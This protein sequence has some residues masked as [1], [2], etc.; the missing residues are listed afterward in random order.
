MTDFKKI[1]NL[2]GWGT[3]FVSM[4]V[5]V[6]TVE[7]TASFWDCGEFIA[8]A[9]KLEVSHPPGAPLFML[10]GRLFSFLSLDDPTRVAYWINISSA[11]ASA[12]SVTFLYWS[13]VMLGRKLLRTTAWKETSMQKMLLV[14][15]GAIGALSFAFT[16]SFWFS[17]VEGEVYAMSSFFTA[18]VFWAML[19]WEMVKDES[20]A[21]KWLL[22]IA[23]M[24]GLSSG[25]HL[26]GLVTLPALG[27][28]YYFKKYK[29]PNLKGVVIALFG[30]LFLIGFINSFIITGLPTAAEFLEIQF[31]N[32]LGLPFGSGALFMAVL[33]VVVLVVSIRVTA[34]KGFVNLNTFLLAMSF[35]L[36]G[37]ACYGVILIRS[38]ANPPI[39]QNNPENAIT[40]TSYLKREQYGSRPLLKGPYFN[41]KVSEINKGSATYYKDEEGYKISDYKTEYSYNDQHLLPRMWSSQPSHVQRYQQI[42]GLRPGESPSFFDNMGFLFNHQLGHMYMRYFMFNFAGRESDIQNADFLAPWEGN[43]GVPKVIKENKGRNQYFA[44]PLILGLIGF[45]F[46][47][48]MDPKRFSATLMFFIL[49]GAALVIYL[50]SAPI[51]PRERDYIYVGSYYVF[52][53]WIGLAVIGLGGA[54]QRKG[55]TALL[56][57]ALSL[58]CPVLLLTENWDDHD[59]SDR[60]FSVDS[61]RNFLASCAP[62]AILFTGGDNDTFP[63]WYVQ[64]V[65]GFR[66]DVRVVVMSYYNTDWYIDQTRM[67]MNDSEP[68]PY[69]LGIDNYRQ[70]TNDYLMVDEELPQHRNEAIDLKQY[71]ELLKEN[72]RFLKVPLRSGDEINA[73]ISRRLKLN[74]DI[75]KVSNADIIPDRLKS[76]MV[77]SM[78]FTVNPSTRALDKAQMMMLDL[79][80]TNEWERPIYFNYT[81]VN[82]LDVDLS[83]YLVQ[84]GMAYRLLPLRN[85]GYTEYM[86]NLDVM[87]DNMMNKFQFRGMD[88]PDVNINED[89]RGFAQNHRSTFTALADALILEGDTARARKVLDYGMEVM[90]RE[91]VP[92]DITSTGFVN[93]Y[94]ALGETEFAIKLGLEMAEEFEDM[95][96]YHLDK[97]RMDNDFRK[98]AGSLQ[99]L[100]LHFENA[101]LLEQAN[102]ITEKLRALSLRIEVENELRR[103]R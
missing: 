46:Q 2:A 103:N 6:L 78:T 60:Y 39:D 28:I 23:Y 35:V 67:K 73:L 79:I 93:S 95:I 92:Y 59:R 40:F 75:E 48:N 51:E 68:F 44:I 56:V 41:D 69:S 29:T 32:S 90:P 45:F 47:F 18:F 91:A 101:G 5:Y 31:V 7:E 76:Y 10:I 15:G 43:K 98:Y 16:D 62:N 25:V 49:T 54:I 14:G 9:Y 83:D 77:P 37:Y 33:V 57:V 88:N 53:I 17:A 1:N 71:L 89:Y 24:M 20:L 81:S 13:I 8:I 55:K 84:E 63:L 70:G 99:Y 65:E 86:T 96:D 38:K 52:A 19:K 100:Q 97:E 58:A 21:N 42:A 3:F 12:F 4:V 72:S 11:V 66:T 80:A 85:P 82:S 36:I 34:Q 26:L 27:L 30:T 87:Y 74:V 61:A 102:V 64:E 50:N 94:L 22:L